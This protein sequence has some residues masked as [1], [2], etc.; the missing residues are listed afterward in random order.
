[1]IHPVSRL[2]QNS[3]SRGSARKACKNSTSWP[4]DDV[5]ICR[6]SQ[7]AP[8]GAYHARK[9]AEMVKCANCGAENPDGRWT[10]VSC[11]VNLPRQATIAGVPRL[12][13][14]SVGDI[15]DET[16]RLYRQNFRPFI[17]IA[18]ILQIPLVILQLAQ[19]AI[20][21]PTGA[22]LLSPAGDLQAGALIFYGLSTL[23]MAFVGLFVAI[24]MQGAFASAI[25]QRYLGQEISVRSAYEAALPFFWRLLQAMFLVTFALTLLIITIIGIPVAIYFGVRWSL[26][27]AA[28]VLEG[29][30]ARAG[31]SRSTELVKGVWW[32]VLGIFALAG[33]GE[34]LIALIPSALLGGVLGVILVVGGPNPTLTYMV[35]LV[36]GTFFGVLAAPIIPIVSILLYYDL[37]IRKEGFDMQMLAASQAPA[38][39]SLI[40]S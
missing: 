9:E 13:A 7:D 34:Y 15:L 29:K 11:G 12:R 25:S 19:G 37:R 31:I 10:C 4:P 35:S 8:C 40:R 27:T 23:L 38:E 22:S 30:G 33:I 2:H 16:V 39:A 36:I 26:S 32:R 17:A 21:G 3:P 28:I 18:A 6:V 20:V 5:Y 14:M 1:M 24:L